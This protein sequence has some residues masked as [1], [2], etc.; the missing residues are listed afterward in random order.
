MYFFFLELWRQIQSSSFVAYKPTGV[1]LCNGGGDEHPPQ[2]FLFKI[3][4][5]KSF[6]F[7]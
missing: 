7:F 2:R 1:G 3:N 4:K 6:Y 5:I